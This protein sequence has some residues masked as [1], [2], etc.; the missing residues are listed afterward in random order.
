[1]PLPL[2]RLVLLISLFLSSVSVLEDAVGVAKDLCFEQMAGGGD[3]IRWPIEDSPVITYSLDKS[4]S[5]DWYEP[6]RLAAATWNSALVAAG[7]ELRFRESPYEHSP[8]VLKAAYVDG[9]DVAFVMGSASEYGLEPSTYDHVEGVWLRRT[10]VE[11]FNTKKKFIVGKSDLENA[12]DLQ[13]VATHEFGHWLGLDDLGFGLLN[14]CKFSSVMVAPLTGIGSDEVRV[15]HEDDIEG[16]RIIYSN[17]HPKPTI[18]IRGNDPVLYQHVGSLDFKGTGFT[19][20]SNDIWI[21]VS[22]IETNKYERKKSVRSNELGVVEWSY[23]ATC[24]DKS[25]TSTSAN[26]SYAT[27][28]QIR[29][30][31]R[32]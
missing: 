31:G 24:A 32:V 12:Y 27:L 22:P 13:G 9:G 14:F 23:G 5:K 4:I 17:L 3:K 11:Y 30:G 28:V 16:L 29:G 10:I 2:V 19:P 21:E 18:F 26:G 7:T 6:I 15:I 8:N 1:M 25:C 20:L